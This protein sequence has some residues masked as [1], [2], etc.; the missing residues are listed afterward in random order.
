MEI[1][2]LRGFVP[3]PPASLAEVGRREAPKRLC[4]KGT[5]RTQRKK[6]LSSCSSRPPK[7]ARSG[8]GGGGGAL[9][10]PLHFRLFPAHKTR[11]ISKNKRLLR[12]T[13]SILPLFDGN[14]NTIIQLFLARSGLSV[15]CRL[16]FAQRRGERRGG[17]GN[18]PCNLWRDIDLQSCQKKQ[19]VRSPRSLRLREPVFSSLGLQGPGNRM[20]AQ[21]VQTP[22]THPQ[23][24]KTMV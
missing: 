7:P 23:L 22:L 14:A 18:R 10:W 15:F 9:L 11:K 3:L 6:F 8:R 2:D 21:T 20:A 19:F 5:H 16:L 17:K 13:R 4:H 24:D 12:F 1:N